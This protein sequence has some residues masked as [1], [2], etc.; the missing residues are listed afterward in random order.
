MDPKATAREES[1]KRGAALEAA[2]PRSVSQRGVSFRGLAGSAIKAAR[3]MRQSTSNIAAAMRD[4]WR[5]AAIQKV[6]DA[7]AGKAASSK[8]YE[9]ERYGA[10]LALVVVLHT[11]NASGEL[12]QERHVGWLADNATW[13]Q[14]LDQIGACTSLGKAEIKELTFSYFDVHDGSMRLLSGLPS[15][16]TWVD[17]SWL[18]HPLEIHVHRTDVLS[19]TAETSKMVK[20]CFD[21][22]DT[23]ASGGLSMAEMRVML[24]EL[25][26]GLEVSTREVEAWARDQFEKADTDGNV[27]MSLLNALNNDHGAHAQS[28]LRLAVLACR[29]HSLILSPI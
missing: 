21:K 11:L 12:Q 7:L 27:P 3:L 29:V 28:W 13:P 2:S 4:V 19:Q 23:D 17:R 1:I 9:L 15:L 26:A 25:C 14:F 5:S 8:T 20:D 24:V 18:H 16:R 22:Y 10:R 6:N